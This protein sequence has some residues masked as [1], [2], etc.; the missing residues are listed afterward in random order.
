MASHRSHAKKNA[1]KRALLKKK[2][3]RDEAPIPKPV[4]KKGRRAP[5]AI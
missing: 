5:V 3:G 4:V 1:K 2:Q